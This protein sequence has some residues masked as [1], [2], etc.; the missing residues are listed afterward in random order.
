MDSI[1]FNM[2]TTEALTPA[3]IE[4]MLWELY[5][6]SYEEMAASESL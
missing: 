6:Y 4:P 3:T 5:G 1:S 2:P